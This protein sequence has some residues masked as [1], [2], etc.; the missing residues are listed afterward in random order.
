MNP[1]WLLPVVTLLLGAAAAGRLAGR[2][3]RESR[4]TAAAVGEALGALGAVS[5]EVERLDPHLDRL[6]DR[7]RRWWVRRRDHRRLPS[8]P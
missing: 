6:T 1:L 4:A 2:V 3:A 5:A 7:R 8:S